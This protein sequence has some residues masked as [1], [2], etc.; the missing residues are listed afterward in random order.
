MGGERFNGGYGFLFC[1]HRRFLLGF[2]PDGLFLCD[3]GEFEGMIQKI[4]ALSVVVVKIV[5]KI[6]EIVLVMFF[7]P[8]FLCIFD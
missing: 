4:I 2:E 3:V 6:L 8:H 1:C 5:D 7:H